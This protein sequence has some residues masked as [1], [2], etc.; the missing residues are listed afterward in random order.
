VLAHPERCLAIQK[1][2]ALLDEA[3]L[4]GAL[5]Q[6]VGPSLFGQGPSAISSAAWGLIDA[7]RADLLASDAHR[8]YSSRVQMGPIGDLVRQRYGE[9][10]LEALTITNPRRLLRPRAQ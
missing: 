3:R 1:H 9:A 6:I 7:G 5:V 2:P 4:D 8:E 10:A